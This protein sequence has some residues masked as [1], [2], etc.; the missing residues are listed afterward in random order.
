MEQYY[1]SIREQH[2]EQRHIGTALAQTTN[3][4]MQKIVLMCNEHFDA[5]TT[6]VA[7]PGLEDCLHGNAPTITICL[8][9]NNGEYD[10]TTTIVVTQTWIY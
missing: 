3:D 4:L 6:I 10:Y 5:E 9:D 1:F 2:D 8:N 7:H